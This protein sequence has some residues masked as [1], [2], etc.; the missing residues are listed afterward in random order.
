[1][2][3][4]TTTEKSEL[5]RL[6]KVIDKGQ[7]TFVEVGTAL[8]R[9]RDAR[10]YR[11]QHDAFADYCVQVWGFT[12]QRASQLIDAAKIAKEC[13][14]VVDIPN[15]RVARQVSSISTDDREKVLR[16]AKENVGDGPLTAKAVADADAAFMDD[17]P[18]D[19]ASVDPDVPDTDVDED[20]EELPSE[21]AK[22]KP[23]TVPAAWQAIE[24][25]VTEIATTI[26]NRG[27]MAD[28]LDCIADEFDKQSAVA[29]ARLS[30]LATKIRKG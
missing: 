21:P 3:A 16:S 10:L 15:E 8:M 27:R 7:K 14:P 24:D 12:K 4:L 23:E 11:E 1:M 17:A 30:N 26:G 6:E 13:Q 5:Q 18:I 22:R 19:V 29:F 20:D 28:L 25:E 9:I 2:N